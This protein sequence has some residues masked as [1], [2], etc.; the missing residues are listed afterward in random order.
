MKGSP[1]WFPN[2]L[3]TAPED[4]PYRSPSGSRLNDTP[5][6]LVIGSYETFTNTK[7]R[8]NRRMMPA[9]LDTF[10]FALKSKFW[11]NDSVYLLLNS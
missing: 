11:L 4:S 3:C 8:S 10:S 1:Y 9:L 6:V 5:L 2:A 7:N